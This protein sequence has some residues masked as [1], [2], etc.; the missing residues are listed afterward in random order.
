MSITIHNF[1]NIRVY[2]CIH[3]SLLGIPKLHGI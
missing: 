1:M 3:L 2:V